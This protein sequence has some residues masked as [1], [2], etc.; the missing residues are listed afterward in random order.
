MT[1]E[2]KEKI[3]TKAGIGIDEIQKFVPCGRTKAYQIRKIC[4]DEFNGRAGVATDR[5]T[6]K[7]LCLALGTTIE[8]ELRIIYHA[9]A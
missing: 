8:E 1:I 3:L 2:E 4:I 6:P 7:S 9:K 5:I